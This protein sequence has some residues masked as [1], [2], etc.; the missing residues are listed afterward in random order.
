MLNYKT[1][2]LAAGAVGLVTTVSPAPVSAG[3]YSGKTFTMIVGASPA[4]GQ[5]RSARAWARYLGK[6]M[7]G[8]PKF[9]VK[10]LPGAAG[11]K[12]KNY[13]YNKAKKRRLYV[14]LGTHES[15]G[16]LAQAQGRQFRSGKIS[17]DRRR[18]CFLLHFDYGQYG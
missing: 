8:K 9:I 18:R 7:P 12:S 2:M 5:S 10:N 1:T 14:A 3:D 13:I 4:G 6:Y 17:I 16:P 15:D 11:N